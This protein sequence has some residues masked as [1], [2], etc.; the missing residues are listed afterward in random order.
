MSCFRRLGHKYITLTYVLILLIQNSLTGTEEATKIW[1]AKYI[2]RIYLYGENLSSYG[3]IL[4]VEGQGGN[5][6]MYPMFFFEQYSVIVNTQNT[7]ALF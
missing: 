7:Q 3:V 2:T 4:K 5:R 6:P 1:E